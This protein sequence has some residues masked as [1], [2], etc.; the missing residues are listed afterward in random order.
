M[1]D[2]DTLSRFR[3]MAEKVQAHVVDVSDAAAGLAYAADL[4][5]RSKGAVAAAGLSPEAE[6]LFAAAVETAGVKRV[7]PPFRPQPAAI[8]TAVTPAL[9]GIAETG[10]LVLASSDEDFRIAGMLSEVHVVLLPR[11]NIRPTVES[12]QA[13]IDA[14]I[15]A[16][17]SYTA[18]VTGASRT[19]DIERVLTVGVHG[20]R[21]LHILVTQ[22]V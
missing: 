10:T 1:T 6:S 16:P 21:A 8:H 12:L 9:W 15:R 5:A 14:L 3:E 22:S 4:A 2:T 20:P 19:A 7:F 13:E 18:F 17:G 11:A